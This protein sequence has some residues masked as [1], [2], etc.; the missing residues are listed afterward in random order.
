VCADTLL[1][2]LCQR[3]QFLGSPPRRRAGLRKRVWI[4]RRGYL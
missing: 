4:Q 1:S 2:T 3:Q